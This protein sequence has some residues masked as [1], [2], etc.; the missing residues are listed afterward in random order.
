MSKPVAVKVFG[1]LNIVFGSLGLV[2]SPLNFLNLGQSIELLQAEGFFR[3]WLSL[4]VFIAPITSLILL[5]L[6]IGLLRYKEWGRQGTV[7][8]SWFTI[9]LG[10]LS[11]VI[12]VGSLAGQ[13]S[14]SNPVILGAVIGGIIGAVVGLIYPIVSLVFLTRPSAKEACR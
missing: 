13:L 7:I 6:G 2:T 12:T 14:D 10:I 11:G 8:Y 5:I 1:I 4:T 9:I 3:T